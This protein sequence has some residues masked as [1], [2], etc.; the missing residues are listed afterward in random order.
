MHANT[1]TEPDLFAQCAEVDRL[2]TQQ[3]RVLA[4][5][6]AQGRAKTSELVKVGGHRF[7]ARLERLRKRGFVILLVDRDYVH[8]DNVYELLFE[9][10]TDG[11]GAARRK[12][13]TQ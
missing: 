2:E 5:L 9:P 13:G 3:A 6:R 7:G 4:L 8:G 11:T 1:D 12:R 10:P